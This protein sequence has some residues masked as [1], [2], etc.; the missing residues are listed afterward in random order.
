MTGI[1]MGLGWLIVAG[2][3]WL[4]LDFT[5]NGGRWVGLVF[6]LLA[7]ERLFVLAGGWP[8]QPDLDMAGVA[9]SAMGVALLL[10]LALGRIVA[11]RVLYVMW[12]R[13]KVLF[14]RGGG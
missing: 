5:R 1:E 2:L 9:V 12:E 4:A 3:T 7:V 13:R 10:A 11:G 6:G 14:G 8:V